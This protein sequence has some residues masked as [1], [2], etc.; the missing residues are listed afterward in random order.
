MGGIYNEADVV[1][2]AEGVHSFTVHGP[3]NALPMV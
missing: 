3:V 1:L 2:P